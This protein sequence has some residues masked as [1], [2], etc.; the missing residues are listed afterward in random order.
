MNNMKSVMI[1]FVCVLLHLRQCTH[2]ELNSGVSKQNIERKE[3]IVMAY[4]IPWAGTLDIGPRIGPAI[5]PAL[6]NVKKKELIPGYEVEMHLIDTLCD[7]LMGMKKIMDLWL[8]HGVD[9][10]IGDGC[11]T[12]CLPV[13]LI[14]SVWNIPIISWECVAAVLSD[15]VVH[16]TFSRVTGPN[17]AYLMLYVKL[18]EVFNWRRVGIVSDMSEVNIYLGNSL[19]TEFQKRN[20]SVFY[21]KT[22]STYN[23]GHIDTKALAQLQN[24]MRTLKTMVRIIIVFTY[25][26]DYEQIIKLAHN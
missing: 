12:V 17:S 4:L 7:K 18:L 16:N 15:K 24:I 25:D 20:M 13:S 10:I 19:F 9:V 23:K 26:E 1:M 22:Q 14:A 3:R 2:F 5:L 11:S 8:H 21:V 6:K